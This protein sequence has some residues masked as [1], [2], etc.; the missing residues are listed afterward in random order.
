M[1]RL[2]NISLQL[3]KR[4][5]WRIRQWKSAPGTQR[6]GLRPAP[7]TPAPRP[8]GKRNNHGAQITGGHVSQRARDTARTV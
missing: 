6:L 1:V 7:T 5:G 8:G 3:S 2:R 4:N